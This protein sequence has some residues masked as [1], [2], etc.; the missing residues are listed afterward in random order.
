MA[1]EGAAPTL[2]WNLARDVGEVVEYHFMVN[3][4]LAG[5]VVAVAAGVAGWM[6]VVRREA[7]AGHTL[8][9]MSFPGAAGAALAGV[10]SAWGYYLACLA[11]ALAISRFR[12][13]GVGDASAGIALV[14]TGALA[15]GFLFLTLYGGVLGDLETQLFGTFLGV[16]DSRLLTLAVVAVAV[17][18]G[19]GAIGRPL[20][21]ASVDPA[22]AAARGLPVVALGTAFLVLLGLAVAAT[23]QVTGALLVFALLVGPPASA[24]A[25]APRPGLGLALTVA[26][27]L[28]VAWLG[29][30]ISYFSSYPAGFFIATI[31]FAV[32]VLARTGAA[33]RR[34]ARR[35]ARPGASQQAGAPV[36]GEVLA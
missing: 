21:F 25:I 18:A 7:F 31:S 20:L 35:P 24:Q 8:S 16:S 22:V 15:L 30:G 36:P 32:Y 29:L 6:M 2:T 33:V 9:V 10:P 4:L 19:L 11:G 12:R 17:L 14:Q 13:R 27:G 23:S 3:A 28:T 1:A 5:T 26:L 34:R